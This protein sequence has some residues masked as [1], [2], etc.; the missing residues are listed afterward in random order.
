MEEIDV[1]IAQDVRM[2]AVTGRR[3]RQSVCRSAPAVSVCE[4]ERSS[5]PLIPEA[6]I[7]LSERDFFKDDESRKP[8]YAS[9]IRGNTP[10]AETRRAEERE[11]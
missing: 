7:F 10:G 1:R 9:V 8:V 6:S 4:R 3:S 5:S 2:D 11:S